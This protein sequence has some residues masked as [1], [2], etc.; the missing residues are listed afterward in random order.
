MLVAL[1]GRLAGRPR[2]ESVDDLAEIPHGPELRLNDG[3]CDPAGRFWVG[4][5]ALD[6][7]LAG[8]RCTATP[9]RAASTGWKT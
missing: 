1:A 6:D 7:A 3:V 9:R 5:M 8:V 2:D 4:T